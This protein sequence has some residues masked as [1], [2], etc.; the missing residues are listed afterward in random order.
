LYD[1]WTGAYKA[2]T[3]YS[4]QVGVES[5]NDFGEDDLKAGF[6][7]ADVIDDGVPALILTPIN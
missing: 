6:S 7:E 5:M 2:D 3:A 1:F 4:G